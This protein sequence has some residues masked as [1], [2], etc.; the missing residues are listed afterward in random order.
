MWETIS[1]SLMG[2]PMLV[3]ILL[4]SLAPFLALLLL[5]QR[6]RRGKL[7]DHHAETVR[8]MQSAAVQSIRRLNRRKGTPT[9]REDARKKLLRFQSKVRYSETSARRNHEVHLIRLLEEAAKHG[10]TVTPDE[11]MVEA[12]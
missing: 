10:I 4:L 8:Q 3:V 2:N 6:L 5:W 11:K 9:L 7:P 12:V 1:P